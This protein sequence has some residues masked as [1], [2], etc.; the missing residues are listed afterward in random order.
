MQQR[1]NFQG[2]SFILEYGIRHLKQCPESQKRLKEYLMRRILE[3]VKTLENEK[4]FEKELKYL[5]RA[6]KLGIEIKDEN[7]ASEIHQRLGKVFQNL[8]E[9]L[10]AK[11]HLD[12]YEKLNHRE[13]K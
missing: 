2:E 1:I 8:N 12:L 11:E 13:E 9:P 6:R 3:T 5:E 7:F 4:D 10:K